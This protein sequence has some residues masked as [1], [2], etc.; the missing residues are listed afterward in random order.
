M[1]IKI[2]K[3]E[4]IP[5]IIYDRIF[6]KHLKIVQLSENHDDEPPKY[7]LIME[8]TI[9]GVDDNNN[10]HFLPKVHVISID[11]YVKLATLKAQAGDNDLIIAM[12]AMQTA[13]AKVLEDQ[14][15]LGMATVI[16]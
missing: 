16:S 5:A 11:D 4:S 14:E 10:R 8:Y 6:V 1:G 9:Y 15:D 13:I 3:T 12:T 7:S 2:T